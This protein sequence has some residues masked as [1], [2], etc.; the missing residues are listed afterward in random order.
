MFLN[1]LSPAFSGPRS[2]TEKLHHFGAITPSDRSIGPP[3]LSPIV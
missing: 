3:T 1:P 2:F